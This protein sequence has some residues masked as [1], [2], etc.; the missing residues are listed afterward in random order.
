[1]DAGEEVV[2]IKPIVLSVLDSN[3]DVELAIPVVLSATDCD[4]EVEVAKTTYT[5]RFTCKV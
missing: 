4:I 5:C 3:T 2:I 1:M